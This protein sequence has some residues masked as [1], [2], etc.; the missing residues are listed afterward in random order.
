MKSSSAQAL[1]V[2]KTSPPSKGHTVA[3]ELAGPSEMTRTHSKA[4]KARSKG[5][6]GSCS[7]MGKKN[8]QESGATNAV[9]ATTPNSSVSPAIVLC[10]HTCFCA[11]HIRMSPGTCIIQCVVQSILFHVMTFTWTLK[12]DHS[13]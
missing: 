7:F 3:S 6:R 12:Q 13:P 1:A 5:A 9:T 2:T 10:P 8:P 4:C 11:F